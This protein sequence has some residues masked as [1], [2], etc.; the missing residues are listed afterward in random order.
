METGTYSEAVLVSCFVD[1]RFLYINLFNLFEE[2]PIIAI[3]QISKLRHR[4]LR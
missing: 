4:E 3:H 2:G 1:F